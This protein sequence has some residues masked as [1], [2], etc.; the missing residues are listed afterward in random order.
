MDPLMAPHL[1]DELTRLIPA[2]VGGDRDAVG[3]V[4]EWYRDYLTVLVRIQIGRR[5][6]KKVDAADVVQDVFLDAHRQFSH[7]HG[8]TGGEL[9]AWLRTLLAGHIAKFIRHYCHTQAR[10]VEL[11]RTIEDELNSSSERMGHTASAGSTPSATAV[12]REGLSGLATALN[13][14][15][16][17]YREVILLRQI[18]DLTFAAIAERM[19]RSVD[20]VQK[21]WV[22]GLEALRHTLDTGFP[23]G[24]G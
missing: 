15:S 24:T 6:Q 1:P 13:E 3:T 16:P 20:S 22:R 17:D 14:L 21:L 4:L 23:P 9:S 5:L 12:K 8:T 11:E 2:A 7:F 10:N 18:E 19:G